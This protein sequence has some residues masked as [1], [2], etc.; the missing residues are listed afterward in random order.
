[1]PIVVG[2]GITGSPVGLSRVNGAQRCS[3]GNAIRRNFQ[4]ALTRTNFNR[5]SYKLVDMIGYGSLV[6]LPNL[7]RIGSKMASPGGGEVWPNQGL[8]YLFFFFV[9]RDRALVTPVGRFGRVIRQN[10]WFGP[11][12]C[13]LGFRKENFIVFTPKIPQNPTFWPRSMHF[14]WKTKMLITLEP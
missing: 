4:H 3:R 8:A 10:A 1:V 11:R 14:L 6:D 5:M 12:M 9:S 7:V 13:L 2:V